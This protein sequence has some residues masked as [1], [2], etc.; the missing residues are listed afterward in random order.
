MKSEVTD[1]T[2]ADNSLSINLRMSQAFNRD[3]YA[4]RML[5]CVR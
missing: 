1:V 3:F 5:A 4:C 2:Q